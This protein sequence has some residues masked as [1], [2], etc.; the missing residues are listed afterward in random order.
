ML[1]ISITKVIFMKGERR[2]RGPTNTRTDNISRESG[3][4]MKKYWESITIKMEVYLRVN[5]QKGRCLME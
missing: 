5:F 4:M 1:T 2:V 3:K